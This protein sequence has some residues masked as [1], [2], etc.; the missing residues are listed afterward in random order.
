VGGSQ[1]TEMVTGASDAAA[2]PPVLAGLLPQPAAVA[3]TVQAAS[4][5]ASALHRW[6]TCILWYSFS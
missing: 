4:A 2:P 5:I 1:L 3:A 6:K